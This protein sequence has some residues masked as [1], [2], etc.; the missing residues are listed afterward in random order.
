MWRWRIPVR[1]WI[2]SSDVSIFLASSSFVTIL[3]GK[4]APHP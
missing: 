4:Y 2:H 3:S 1:C